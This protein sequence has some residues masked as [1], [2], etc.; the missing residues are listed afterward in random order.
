MEDQYKNKRKYKEV[1]QNT[2]KSSNIN[3]LIKIKQLPK[4]Y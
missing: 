1:L 3:E 2:Y 4:L